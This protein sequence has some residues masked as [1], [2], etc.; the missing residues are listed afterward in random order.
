ME[1]CLTR[2]KSLVLLTFGHWMQNGTLKSHLC[3][4]ALRWSPCCFTR[5]QLCTTCCCT[6]RDPRW[7]FVWLEGCRRWWLCCRETTWN[8]LLSPQTVYRFWRTAIK[9]AR[10]KSIALCRVPTGIGEPG[11]L[12]IPFP[13]REN[14]RFGQIQGK[15]RKMFFSQ[16]NSGKQKLHGK[17]GTFWQ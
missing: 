5:S 15:S 17:D 2:R 6:R 14:D 13:V 8:S 10:W 1:S 12:T 4:A 7:R 9:R 3:F 11:N 16:E